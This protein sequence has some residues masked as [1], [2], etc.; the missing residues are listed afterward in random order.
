MGIDWN[1]CPNS[2]HKTKLDIAG[3][4]HSVPWKPGTLKSPYALPPAGAKRSWGWGPSHSRTLNVMVLAWKPNQ[5]HLT[6]RS[7]SSKSFFCEDYEALRVYKSFFINS[8]TW[9]LAMIL[10]AMERSLNLASHKLNHIRST[11]NKSHLKWNQS[12]MASNHD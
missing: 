12:S 8:G 6:S 11:E 9:V 1:Q 10:E 7:L 2:E 5:R 4:Q 3:L